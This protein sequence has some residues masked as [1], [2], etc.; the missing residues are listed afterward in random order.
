MTHQ[1]YQ[2]QQGYGRVP[3][4]PRPN[5]DGST[6]GKSAYRLG[7]DFERSIRGR[8]ERKGYFVQRQQGSKGK[9][10]LLAVGLDKPVLGVQAKRRGSI[11]SQEWNELYDLCVAHGILPVVAVKEFET[12]QNSVAYYRLDA[13]REFGKRGRPWTTIDHATGE[14]LP[15]QTALV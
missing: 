8:L 2:R 13:R 15:V 9:I 12:G 11:S 4:K 14:P 7:R 3:T 5:A 10:D 1:P 6:G